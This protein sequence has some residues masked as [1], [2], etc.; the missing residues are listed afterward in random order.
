MEF[1]REFPEE[2]I[3]QLMK[4]DLFKGKLKNDITKG[5]DQNKI[6]CVF[7]AIRNNLI[8]F[9]WG[10]GNLFSYTLD[11]GFATHRKYAAVLLNNGNNT[12]KDYIQETSLENG[13]VRLIKNF[14]ED[15]NRIKENCK[16]YSGKEALGVSSLYERFS[17]A[18]S[19][20]SKVVVL[21]IEASFARN[22]NE[23]DSRDGSKRKKQDRI[24]L[25]IFDLE[26]RTIR[27]V[28]AK[29]YDNTELRSKE[30]PAVV[31]QMEKYSK[32]I[33]KREKE[34]LKA[35]K[36]H[37]NIINSL[38]RSEN[39]LPD[40]ETVD[41][42]PILFIFGFDDAQRNDRLRKEIEPKLE[43]NNLRFYCKGNVKNCDLLTLFTGGGKF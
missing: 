30:T 28:E 32:Q 16:L 27:F 22:D 8:D 43:K 3:E 38:F 31:N 15:Y 36:N 29:H 23:G 10:G 14:R 4:E 6:H 40:P 37:V 13:E 21:D 2:A 25:V 33:E 41:T 5:N 20:A 7:P 39:P 9:Y 19:S 35:Y 1:K 26:S 11:K 12:D 42:K 24:D 18:S 17:C 34:I